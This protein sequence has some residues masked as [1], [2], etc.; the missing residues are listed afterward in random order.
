MQ[1][2]LDE[3]EVRLDLGPPTKELA[4]L[5]RL[6][7]LIDLMLAMGGVIL[8]WHSMCLPYTYIICLMGEM[9]SPYNHFYTFR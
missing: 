8:L 3:F 5:E 9:V 4:V 2:I 6:K 7:Y 1:S